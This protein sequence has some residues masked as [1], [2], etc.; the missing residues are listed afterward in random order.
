[1]MPVFALTKCG[2]STYQQDI[3][4]INANELKT[5]D[6]RALM[7]IVVKLGPSW[8]VSFQFTKREKMCLRNRK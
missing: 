5:E 2:T 7:L 8:N 6:F 3:A 4:V 1:M